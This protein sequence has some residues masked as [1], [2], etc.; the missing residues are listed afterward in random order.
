MIH[1]N[2]LWCQRAA[3][4][5]GI[6]F[7]CLGASAQDPVDKT[8]NGIMPILPVGAPQSAPYKFPLS[9]DTDF[10]EK[11]KSPDRGNVFA[12][13]ALKPGPDG[14]FILTLDEAQQAATAA[15]NPLVRLGELQVESARRHRLGVEAQYFPNLS[16]SFFDLHYNKHPGEVL[17]AGPLG[18]VSVNII[19]KDS[20]TLNLLA[21]QP[22][23]P[24][25]SIYQLAKIARA[26]ENIARAKAGM[27]VAETASK[28]EK[29]F[30]ELLVAQRELTGTKAHAKAIQAKWLRASNSGVTSISTEQETDMISAEKAVIGPASKVKELT[31]SLD[32]MLGLPKGT[33]LELVAPDPL[34][35]NISLD[36]ASEKATAN[37]EVIEAEQTA[38]KA[39]AGL[40]LTKLTYV[41][42]AGVL[43]GYAFQ[44]AINRVLPR[45]FG[46]I[47][48]SASWTIFD[49]GKREQ[50]VKESKANA[51]MA[52]LG[53]QLTKAK[54]AAAVKSAYFELERSR[55]FT[56]LARRM[57]SATQVVE[58]S[59]K[60]DDPEVES[61]RATME[62][63]MFRAE[64]EYRQAYAK[65]KTLMGAQ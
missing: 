52:D 64:L 32:E 15:S 57:M 62:A 4:S 10:T 33:K 30:F 36:E 37:P 2:Q 22:I 61:A 13:A 39:H 7:A 38:I 23:T 17:S 58:A 5:I 48:A 43:G 35:E 16:T 20:N 12:T 19:N 18:T 54:V 40:A 60:P 50:G 53:V 44:D 26:D 49:F 55:Q 25:F 28:V 21:V 31:A 65:V 46:Y 27:P 8:P 41:P 59:Y 14:V 24:L 11:V 45:S 3:L 34:V 6:F 29:T 63:D 56:Q 47:G 9:F 42:T 1:F 51:E